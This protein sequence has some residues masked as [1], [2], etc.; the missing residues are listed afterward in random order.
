MRHCKKGWSGVQVFELNNTEIA[1]KDT[2]S[3]EQLKNKPKLCS[4]ADTA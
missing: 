1:M 3:V 2:S 4:Q